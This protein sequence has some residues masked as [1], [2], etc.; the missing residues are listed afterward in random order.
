M[1]ISPHIGLVKDKCELLPL[2][3]EIALLKFIENTQILSYVS[4]QRVGT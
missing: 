3:V 4:E 2:R 1:P